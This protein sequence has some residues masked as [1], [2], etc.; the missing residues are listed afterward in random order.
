MNHRHQPVTRSGSVSDG[1]E[2]VE[3]GPTSTEKFALCSQL[4]EQRLRLLQVSRIKTLSK[5]A[6]DR[7][8]QVTGVVPLALLP[9]ESTQA[10][11]RTEFQRFRLVAGAADSSVAI[12][13]RYLLCG[14]YS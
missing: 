2:R 7:G 6:I 1:V 8:K 10:G 11:C 12:G 5:P 9:P 14:N 4:A 3:R 13:L